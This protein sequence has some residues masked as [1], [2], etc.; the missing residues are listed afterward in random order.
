MKNYVASNEV[1]RQQLSSKMLV[2]KSVDK[3]DVNMNYAAVLNQTL[4]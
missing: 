4:G 3:D 1:A 2:V